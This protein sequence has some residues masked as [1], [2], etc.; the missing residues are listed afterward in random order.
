M[1]IM[2]WGHLYSFRSTLLSVHEIW[3]KHF[4][5][6]LFGLFVWFSPKFVL[7]YLQSMP[8]KSYGFPVQKNFDIS[9]HF[10]IM[11]HQSWHKRRIVF[12]VMSWQH[13]GLLH[14]NLTRK[15]IA[16]L[17]GLLRSLLCLCRAWPRNCCSQVIFTHVSVLR[18][19]YKKYYWVV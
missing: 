3:K 2:T 4:F 5:F 10:H 9:N 6:F 7:D 17:R 12:Y 13:Y 19:S 14:W 1:S 16:M 18:D 11:R 8:A 15:I